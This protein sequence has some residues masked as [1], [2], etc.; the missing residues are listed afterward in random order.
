MSSFYNIEDF[1]RRARTRLP[2]IM[3]DFIDGAAGQENASY[4][5]VLSLERLRLLPKVLQNVVERDLR[6]SILGEE[7]HLPIGIAPMGMC[8]LAW[9]GTDHAFAEAARNQRI[10]L[11][12]STAASSSIEEMME[13][14]SGRTW[15]QL[16][17][18]AS[19]EEGLEKVQRVADA[20]CQTLILTVDVPEVAPRWRDLHNGFKVPFRIGPKQFI[21]FASHPRWVIETLWHGVPRPV[22]F[23]DPNVKQKDGQKAKGFNR[24]ETRGKVDWSFLRQLR[25]QWAGKLIV[26]GV[27]SPEDAKKIQDY[28]ADAIYVSNHGGRQLDSA[29]S[30]I[31]R[32]PVIREALG[33]G[34]PLIFDSGIRNGEGVVKALALGADFVMLGRPFLYAAGAAG[35]KGVFRMIELLSNEISLCMA[36]LGMNRLEQIDRNAVFEDESVF[37]NPQSHGIQESRENS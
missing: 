14:S 37:L 16:Y 17:V 21:D 24:E 23:P 5:N 9:A 11:C 35:R 4:N 26:K 19:F 31:S 27:L 13:Q 10:P 28:G 33:K 36:Q 25:D 1:R 30:A 22:H 8:D 6:T 34:F 3:F 20:G 32:L 7:Y 2:K 29:P 15:F 18:G 12:L